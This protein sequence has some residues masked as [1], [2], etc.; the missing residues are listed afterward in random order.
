M[1]FW[2]M[3]VQSVIV[4]SFACSVWGFFYC[5]SLERGVLCI[6]SFIF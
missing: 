1:C 3:Y 5:V 6:Q 2:P 4:T